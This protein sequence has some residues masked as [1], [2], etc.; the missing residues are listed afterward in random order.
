MSVMYASSDGGTNSIELPEPSPVEG[1]GDLQA[2]ETIQSDSDEVMSIDSEDPQD[3]LSPLEE[4]EF[5]QLLDNASFA[6]MVDPH[7]FLDDFYNSM[8]HGFEV[9]DGTLSLDEDE[10]HE[11]FPIGHARTERFSSTT[12]PATQNWILG[13]WFA[14]NGR[15][16]LQ[17][18]L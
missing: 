6:T 10:E 18:G 9:N 5:E 16:G 1:S 8:D 4:D 2:S 13:L 11:I 7:Q 14:R 15:Q 17:E 12:F 3:P